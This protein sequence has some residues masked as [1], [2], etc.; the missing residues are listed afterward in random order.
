MSKLD[1]NTCDEKT[2]ADDSRNGVALS[3]VNKHWCVTDSHCHQKEISS[4]LR[5]DSNHTDTSQC[6]NYHVTTLGTINIELEEQL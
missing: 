4:E 2:S 6:T 3:C 5:A 1:T